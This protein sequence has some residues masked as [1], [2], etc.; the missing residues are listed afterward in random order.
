MSGQPVIG[1]DLGDSGDEL[2]VGVSGFRT[3]REPDESG[4]GAVLES[5]REDHRAAPEPEALAQ[6]VLLGEMR[7]ELGARRAPEPAGEPVPRA[8]LSVV[9]TGVR[10]GH[11]ETFGIVTATVLGDPSGPRQPAAT[12]GQA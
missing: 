6:G 7:V 5:R 1:I 10:A 11:N 3:P 2:G 9:R 8:G 4:C 12:L